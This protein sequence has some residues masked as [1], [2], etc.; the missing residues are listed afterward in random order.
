MKYNNAQN[1]DTVTFLDFPKKPNR[2]QAKRVKRQRASAQQKGINLRHIF[3]ITDN[4]EKAFESFLYNK[5]ILLHGVAGTGKTFISLYLALKDALTTK[6]GNQSVQIIRSVVPTRDMGF[7]PGN[8]KEKSKAYEE[9]YYSICNELFDRGDVYDIL[10]RK[11]ILE[12][13]TTSFIRGLTFNNTTVIVDECQNMTWHELDSVITR[14]GENSR[15]IFCG[16]FR[17]SDF[18]WNKD[19]SGIHDFMKVIKTMNSFDFIEFEKD[20]I[21]RSALVKE[22]IISKLELGMI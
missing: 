18:L 11:G 13:S 6:Q 3:P 21:V 4:Q 15:I 8:Q 10:K 16:D 5:N 22:Y 9:P 12:F 14:L 2:K 19:K 7:L 20:D 17:Q 1:Y